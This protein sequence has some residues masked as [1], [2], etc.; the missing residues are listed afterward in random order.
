[1]KYR[2]WHEYRDDPL[3]DSIRHDPQNDESS[4]TCRVHKVEF[5][6]SCPLCTGRGELVEAIE[7]IASG[8]DTESWDEWQLARD[9]EAQNQMDQDEQYQEQA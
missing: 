4:D 3:H 5:F 8:L 7:D 6:G 1:M 2:H 9:Q